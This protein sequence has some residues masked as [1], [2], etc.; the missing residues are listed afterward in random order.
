MNR[1]NQG[2]YVIAVAVMFLSIVP[3]T[4][5]ADTTVDSM[6]T[7]YF[8][9]TQFQSNS[10]SIK[11]IDFNK[12]TP[13]NGIFKGNEYIANG[14]SIKQRDGIGINILNLGSNKF[15]SKDNFSSPPIGI[16]SSSGPDFDCSECSDSFDFIFSSPVTAAGLWV[17]NLNGK[18]QVEFLSSDG[19]V[20][21]SEVLDGNHK[22]II[23]AGSYYNR[24]FYGI[25][26][27]HKIS[28]IRT[29]NAANDGDGV[30]YDDVQFG[31]GQQPV[32][33]IKTTGNWISLGYGD[34]T[35][36]D[37]SKTEGSAV[38]DNNLCRSKN[39]GQTAVC[40]DNQNKRH[41]NG[42]TWCTYKDVIATTCSGGSNPGFLY[43]CRAST[44]VEVKRLSFLKKN[45][46][47]FELIP[48]KILRVGDEFCIEAEFE[49]EPTES[50]FEVLIQGA[51]TPLKYEIFKQRSNPKIF[52]GETR[53]ITLPEA[54]P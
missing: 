1:L 35:A 12:L 34:C 46:S 16:S 17:G 37:V 52:R 18:T 2:F 43:E 51:N 22:G 4:L 6:T 48:D 23:T 50:V 44:S 10:T 33:S 9:L 15:F 11:V 8:D 54:E 49:S 13:G 47:R 40:W 32:A 5:A 29:T 41:T 28:R 14:L 25:T 53:Q 31:V 30:V 24:I 42:K 19:S 45:G 39:A 38:P 26:S 27:A 7:E 21:A 3:Q 36:P 20:I